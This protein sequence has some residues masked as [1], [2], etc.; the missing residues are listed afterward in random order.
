MIKVPLHNRLKEWSIDK[1]THFLV[2]VKILKS[3]DFSRDGL[4]IHSKADIDVETAIYGGEI[5][6]KGL[7]Q[8]K[9]KL[10]IPPGLSSHQKLVINEEGIHVLDMKGDHH[11]EIC[12]NCQKQ[13]LRK[14]TWKDLRAI[15]AELSQDQE[16]AV[17]HAIRPQ[18]LEKSI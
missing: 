16:E 10:N 6:I 17:K 5:E 18:V 2:K 3:E 11:V 8:N 4:N 12:I 9:L 7:R 1:S 15:S 13:K 14:S